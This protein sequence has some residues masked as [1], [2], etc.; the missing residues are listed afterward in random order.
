MITSLFDEV[1]E[2]W[3]SLEKAVEQEMLFHIS[4]ETA[5]IV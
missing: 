1:S 3:I 2:I 5:P 4:A